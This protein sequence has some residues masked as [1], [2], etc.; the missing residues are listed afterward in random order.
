MAGR[1]VFV[2]S[3]NTLPKA[4]KGHY[5]LLRPRR[6]PL[7]RIRP[8]RSF[9][10]VTD[11]SAP[12]LLTTI[13]TGLSE[14][15]RSYWECD[16]GIAYVIAGGKADGWRRGQH[17]NIYNLA[18]PAKPVFIR[19]WG[20]PGGQPSSSSSWT[21]CTNSPGANCFEGVSNPPAAVHQCYST[22]TG[23]T[24]AGGIK[25]S[26]VICSIGVG[27]SGVMQIVDRTKLLNS[28]D[29]ADNPAASA[30]LPA[31]RHRAPAHRRR[32]C[33]ILRSAILHH[34]HTSACMV[35]CQSSTSRFQQPGGMEISVLP[36]P[37][38]T[39][40]STGPGV[41]TTT[42]T[43]GTQ[44]WDI[45]IESSEAGGPPSCG[46]SDNYMHNGTILDITN[47]L[48]PWPISTLNVPTQPGDFCQKGG[49]FGH[50]NRLGNIF[51]V[52]RQTPVCHLVQCRGAGLGHPRSV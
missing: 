23:V 9:L 6:R 32:T 31:L 49:P 20:L 19:Q 40:P 13:V 34:P 48:T 18:D 26:V 30:N 27:A 22:S 10:N 39:S 52:L 12:A 28:C 47:E 35:T 3:G 24:G 50:I 15:H 42:T 51:A 5:Y 44:H 38:I 29:S 43:L 8:N 37:L 2:C 4:T 21:S 7:D 14:Y 11:P 46:T 25:R 45:E 16:T 36:S 41:T 33:S 17:V 1:H